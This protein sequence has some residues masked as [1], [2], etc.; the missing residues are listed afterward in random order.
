MSMV[1]GIQIKA[2]RAFKGDAAMK[3]ETNL[4]AG[5]F[6]EDAAQGAGTA[7]NKAVDFVAEAG[8]EA[9]SLTKTVS[10]TASSVWNTL[11][12]SLNL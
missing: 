7:V 6:L 3:V 8:R 12:S 10:S 1:S 9:D 5:S 4:K 11:S 2:V